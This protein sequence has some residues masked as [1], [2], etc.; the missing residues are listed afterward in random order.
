MRERPGFSYL[1]ERER[2][3]D[4]YRR[5]S[6]LADQTVTSRDGRTLTVFSAGE[7]EASTVL[8]VNPLGVSCLFLV[9]LIEAL[10]RH[11]H[12]VTWETRGLPDYYPDD[13]AA[14]GEWEPE[15]HA[16]DLGEVLAAAGRGHAD[17][18]I[19]YCSG[20][21]LA[22]YATATG[23]IA[24]RRLALIS[25]PLEL[26][27][28]G[29]KTLYQKTFPP[30]LNRI[31]RSGPQLAAL[32]RGIMRQGAQRTE[33]DAD[34][35]LH[36][37]NDLPFTRDETTHRYAR[38]HAPWQALP[39]AGLLG[40]VAV[41]TAIFHGTEDEIVHPDTVAALAAAVPDATLRLYERQGHFAVYK[42]EELIADV[43]RFVKAGQALSHQ[44]TSPSRG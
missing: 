40:K 13:V 26:G 43:A 3:F 6:I 11:H 14:P 33:A 9:G 35:E 19:S 5:A 38:L 30:L 39:W 31:A 15:T 4:V 28:D 10:S 16:R 42:S 12:V 2:G 23:L 1:S 44:A 25:P 20:S 41:P 22:L 36:T 29:E 34:H 32:V 7:P 37:L 8:L 18:V 17:S 21:Y 24:P 27:A